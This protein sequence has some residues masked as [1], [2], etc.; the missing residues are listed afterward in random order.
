M[1]DASGPAFVFAL[2][3]VSIGLDVTVRRGEVWDAGCDVVKGHP[4]LFTA[5][6]RQIPGLVHDGPVVYTRESL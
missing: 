1:K 5:D 6:A 3:T 2:H 4:H